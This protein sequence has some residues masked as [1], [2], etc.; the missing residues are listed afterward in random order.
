MLF[1]KN[2]SLSLTVS[3]SDLL[4]QGNMVFRQVSGNSVIDSKNNVITRVFSFGLT[5]NLSKFGARG[6]AFRVDPD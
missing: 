1:L 5:Y 6:T 2:K 4:N 3:A